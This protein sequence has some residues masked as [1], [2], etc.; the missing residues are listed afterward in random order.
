MRTVFGFFSTL[1][2]RGTFSITTLTY[3]AFFAAHSYIQRCH[4]QP[5]TMRQV[6]SPRVTVTPEVPL[7]WEEA[8]EFF[9]DG[10]KYDT[11]APFKDE[12]RNAFLFSS[13]GIL[14]V[15]Y[16]LLPESAIHIS[17]DFL[18]LQPAV[19]KPLQLVKDGLRKRIRFMPGREQNLCF[20]DSWTSNH[21]HLHVDWLPRLLYFAP[22]E[23]AQI[24]LILPDTAYVRTAAP[25][26]LALFQFA[27]K[28]I[29]YVAPGQILFFQRLL[30]VSKPV[31]PGMAYPALVQA[32]RARL[33]TAP[34]PGGPKKIYIKRKNTTSRALLNNA[35]VEQV[36]QKHGFTI[37]DFDQHTI[38][39][40]AQLVAQTQVLVGMHGAG[41][42]NLLYMPTGATIVEFRRQGIHHN[43]CYWH[44]ASAAGLAYAAV[45]GEPDDASKVLEGGDGC[46]LMLDLVQLER[47]LR[48]AG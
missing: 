6:V 5:F 16:R 27:F 14:Y 17:D 46:N 22:A 40:Q 32:L 21:Y 20:F 41:L 18:K 4:H 45:F 36:V 15:P 28:Q 9:Q 12:L 8:Q 1:G 31:I 42:T 29:V 30:F 37:V 44:L 48:L 34:N 26:I 10:L 2:R 13:T 11:H 33:Q 7:N 19:Y 35:E 3:Q 24:T 43:H 23:A 38:A 47:V 39:E 25:A